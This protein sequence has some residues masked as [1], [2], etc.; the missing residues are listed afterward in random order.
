MKDV[1]HTRYTHCVSCEK[2]CK[3]NDNRTFSDFW[4]HLRRAL[5][6]PK[7]DRGRIIQ[8]NEARAR[9]IHDGVTCARNAIHEYKVAQRRLIMP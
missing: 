4:S 9:Y 8:S 1:N 3:R 7:R 6:E 2:H 5:W